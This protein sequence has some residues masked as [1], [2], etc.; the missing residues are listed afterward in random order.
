MYDSIICRYP[1]P[2]SPPFGAIPDQLVKQLGAKPIDSSSGVIY[3]AEGCNAVRLSDKKGG[4]MSEWPQDLRVR[5]YP[6]RVSEHAS[7]RQ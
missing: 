5:E 3:C 7:I 1:L 4:D 2:G 6:K